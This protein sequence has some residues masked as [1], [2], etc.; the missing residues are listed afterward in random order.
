[1][2]AARMHRI[3]FRP[4]DLDAD[5]DLIFAWLGDPDVRRWYDEGEHSLENYRQRFGPEPTTHKFIM[6]ID[7]QPVGYLQAYRLSDERE[8]AT[9]VALEHD[10]VSIDLFIGEAAYRG[11]GWGSLVLRRALNRIVFGEM[12]A[13]YACCNPDPENTRAI[14]AY[15][16]AGFHG[17]RVV[18][19]KDDAP[20]NTGYERIMT[21][22]RE[23]FYSSTS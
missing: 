11:E 6:V 13:Q 22:S 15:L 7:G 9:Q 3:E 10:A 16:K 5:I 2:E 21:I 14:S 1:M 20:E 23:E 4:V 17:D 8:Y 12:G 18:W 19:I